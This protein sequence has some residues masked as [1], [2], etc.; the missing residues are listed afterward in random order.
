MIRWHIQRGVVVLPKSTHVERIKQN[1]DV[2]DFNLTS[3][4]MTA[5]TALNTGKRNGADPDNF[6]F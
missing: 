4:D 5:I 1:F 3:E 6:D 2:F